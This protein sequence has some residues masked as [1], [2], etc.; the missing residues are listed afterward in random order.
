A[1]CLAASRSSAARISALASR[2]SR[3][4]SSSCSRGSLV[5]ENA[6]PAGRGSC[7]PIGRPS[8][9]GPAA[10][11]LLLGGAAGRPALRTARQALL[12]GSHQVDHLAVVVGRL[13][14]L[15]RLALAL[16]LD[17]RP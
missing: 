3:A 10:A 2:L 7:V 4:S 13:G 15:H 5:A 9:G 6:Q 11:R 12:Q 16:L 14:R 17:Q 8:L 1:P